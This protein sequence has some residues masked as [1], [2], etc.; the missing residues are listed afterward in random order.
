[1]SSAPCPKPARAPRCSAV[2]ADSAWPER[3]RWVRTVALEPLAVQLGYRPDPRNPARWKRPGSVL[4]I[5][6]DKFFDHR[7]GRGGGGAIDL[8]MHARRCRFQAAV[9]FLERHAGLPLPAATPAAVRRPGLR[10]PPPRDRLWPPVRDFLATARG[11]DPAL[12]ERCRHDGILYADSRRN[13]VFVCRDSLHNP[14]GA[15]LVGTRPAPDGRT[16]KGMAPGSR[17]ARGGFWL[18]ANT[19]DL[20]AL[21]VTESA[22]DA[23]SAL[24][25]L[26]PTLPPDTLLA[27]TAGVASALPPWLQAFQAPRTL[28]AYD[29]DPAG[30]QAAADL[31]R[32]TPHCSRLRPVGAKDWNDLLRRPPPR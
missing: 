3:A 25:L 11:L 13:A 29:A 5:S 14:V 4:S 27:S 22:V 21:L 23:L 7:Q 28:C 26:A 20:D 32:H 19:A 10:L 1:M 2:P 8:V 31:R 9:E 24:L 17:K 16:F 15:E 6:G 30:D 12:L 18:P